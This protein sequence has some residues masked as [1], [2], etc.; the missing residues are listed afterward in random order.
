MFANS[1]A[2]SARIFAPIIL[3]PKMTSRFFVLMAGDYSRH[4]DAAQCH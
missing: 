2:C 4:C 1:R 3:P